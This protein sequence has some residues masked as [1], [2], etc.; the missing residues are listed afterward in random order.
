LSY[1]R[2]RA[3]SSCATFGQATQSISSIAKTTISHA[4]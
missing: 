3:R 1:R 2:S 4:G